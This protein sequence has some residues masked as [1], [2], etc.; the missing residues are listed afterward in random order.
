MSKKADSEELATERDAEQEPWETCVSCKERNPLDAFPI[1]RFGRSKYCATCYARPARA[2]V[3]ENFGS[4]RNYKLY[5]KYG[6]TE[7]DFDRMVAK[8]GGLCA[9]CQKRAATQVDHDHKTG[10]VRAILCLKCNAGLGALK[11]EERLVWEAV[12]YLH[13]GPWQAWVS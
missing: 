11:D 5:Q 12:D 1:N 13:P 10:K 9:V 4:Y 7:A 8:Q 6:M 3:M 2:W